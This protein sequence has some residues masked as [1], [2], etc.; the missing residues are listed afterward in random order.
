MS[1][2]TTLADISG[3]IDISRI[4]LIRR[5][6]KFFVGY[7][8]DKYDIIHECGRNHSIPKRPFIRFAKKQG[9]S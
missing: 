9:S 2:K 6:G 7:D 3:L 5:G 4:K 8:F 1:E